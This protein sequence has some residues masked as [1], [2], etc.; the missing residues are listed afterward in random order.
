MLQR[1]CLEP[2]VEMIGPAVIAALEFV[3]VA[4]VVGDHERAA[5]GALIMNDADLA[6]GVAHQHDGLAADEAAE[7]V[8]G[9]LHL[10]FVADIDPGGAENALQFQFEDGRDRCRFADARGRA[11]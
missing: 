10:A 2:A 9:I 7:I 11:G 8:A 1:H 3:G 4:L 6:V 5:M